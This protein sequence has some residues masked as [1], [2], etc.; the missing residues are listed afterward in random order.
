MSRGLFYI[1]L[2]FSVL[3]VF[4]GCAGKGEAFTTFKEPINDNGLLYIYRPDRFTGIV[5]SYDIKDK[6]SLEVIGTLRNA[7]FISKSLPAGRYTLVTPSDELVVTIK[8]NEITCITSYIDMINDLGIGFATHV[9]KP[10]SMTQC[11][12]EI[13]QTNESL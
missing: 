11:K 5:V 4:S 10:V 1:F 13:K 3:F 2:S 7:S 6:H 12:D 9:L 8:K